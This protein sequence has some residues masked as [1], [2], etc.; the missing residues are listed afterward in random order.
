MSGVNHSPLI[1]QVTR[2]IAQVE[3]QLR[4]IVHTSEN[5][6]TSCDCRVEVLSHAREIDFP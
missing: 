1:Y 6:C 3:D 5:H 2:A 4:I